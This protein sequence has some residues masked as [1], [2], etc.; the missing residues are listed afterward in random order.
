MVFHRQTLAF[1]AYA[2][3]QLDA[4]QRR[5]GRRVFA[6]R[7]ALGLRQPPAFAERGL[8]RAGVQQTQPQVA[9]WLWAEPQ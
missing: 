9:T 6:A 5:R 3:G 4:P 2:L 7:A 8:R 1:Y